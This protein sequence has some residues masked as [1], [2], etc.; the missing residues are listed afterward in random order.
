MKLFIT[1]LFFS[2]FAL[3]TA[4]LFSA[5]KVSHAADSWGF[6][7]GNVYEASAGQPLEKATVTA[8]GNGYTVTKKTNQYGA[9]G[10]SLPQQGTY[11]VTFSKTRH[12]TQTMEMYAGS[13][14]SPIE[15]FLVHK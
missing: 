5:P 1:L 14:G 9:Y 3:F 11:T 12:I 6:L 7:V 2:V 10:I 4:A 8:T 15:V 13:T